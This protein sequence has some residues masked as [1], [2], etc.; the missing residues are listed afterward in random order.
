MTATSMK[1][2][3]RTGANLSAARELDLVEMGKRIRRKREYLK[4]TR[5]SLAE[6]IDVSTQFISDLERGRRGMTLGRLWCLSTT[7]DVTTDYLLT[8]QIDLADDGAGQRRLQEEILSL[9]SQCNT[10][11]LEGIREIAH[12][13]THHVKG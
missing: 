10:E 3:G 11:Q 1:A 9:L 5:E 7:L 6:K 13:Y 8:G 2:A 4:M 12:I